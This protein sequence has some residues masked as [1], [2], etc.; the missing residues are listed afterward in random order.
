[1]LTFAFCWLY[2]LYVGLERSCMWCCSGYF[3]EHF[4]SRPKEKKTHQ[5]PF[6]R[7]HQENL[8]EIHRKQVGVIIMSCPCMLYP[9]HVAVDGLDSNNL[10]L[11]SVFKLLLVRRSFK[12]QWDIMNVWMS[13]YPSALLLL[14]QPPPAWLQGVLPW[15]LNP[16][17][18][19]W[20][21]RAL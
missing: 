7:I 2:R 5:C 3:P 21:V 15:K 4:P 19:W 16:T 12:N 8:W 17:K 14:E 6:V 10:L 1:M 20:D 18:M 11:L 13:E 9:E